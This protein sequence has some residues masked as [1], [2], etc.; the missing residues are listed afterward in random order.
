MTEK[1]YNPIGHM[2]IYKMSLEEFTAEWLDDM[3]AIMWKIGHTVTNLVAPSEYVRKIQRWDV[4][5]LRTRSIPCDVP[6]KEKRGYITSLMTHSNI[7][8]DLHPIRE[9][10]GMVGLEYKHADPVQI[11]QDYEEKDR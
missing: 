4:N 6:D 1:L 10:D 7:E 5:R 11:W 3:V 2:D 8:V 9:W